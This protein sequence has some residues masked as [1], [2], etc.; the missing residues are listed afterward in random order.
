M[1][2]MLGRTVELI[3]LLNNMEK[4]KLNTLKDKH[5]KLYSQ[6]INEAYSENELFNACELDYIDET[7]SPYFLLDN[8]NE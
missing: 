7:N 4:D 2:I 5:R 3:L 1:V 6:I 8:T